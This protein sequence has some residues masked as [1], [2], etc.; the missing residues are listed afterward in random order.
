MPIQKVALIFDDQVR[1]D[2]TGIYCRRALTGLVNVQHFLPS[3]LPQ[4]PRRGF[5][6]YLNIDDGLEYTLPGDLRPCAWWA[7]DTH[8]NLE[9]CQARARDFDL[10]FAAQRDGT[11]QLQEAG[12]STACWL[13]LACD[14]EMHRKHKARKKYNVGFVGHLFPGPRADL[15]SLIQ[16]HFSDT[17]VG[18]CFFEEMAKTYSVSR[19]VFNRSIRNDINM[20]VFEAVACGSLLVTNDLSDNG[21]DDLLRDGVHLATYGNADELLDKIKYYLAHEKIRERIAAAG[22]AEVLGR[23]T[24]RHRMQWLLGEAERVL[25]RLA[26]AVGV[27]PDKDRGQAVRTTNVPAKSS[28]GALV[29]APAATGNRRQGGGIETALGETRAGLLALTPESARKILDMG[30]GDG[31]FGAAVKARQPAEVTGVDSD[32]RMAASA[33]GRIDRVLVGDPGPRSWAFRPTHS[34][35]LSAQECS[36]I[37]TIRCASCAGYATGFVQAVACWQ[38]SVTFAITRLSGPC[39]VGTGPMN[40]RDSA[41][42]TTSDLSRA[43]TSRSCFTAPAS[44]SNNGK[45]SAARGMRNGR[46]KGAAGRFVPAACTWVGCLRRTPRSFTSGEYLLSATPSKLLAFGTTSIVV[47][48]HNQLAYTRMCLES[49]RRRTDEP[50]ELIVVDNGSTDGT[51][52]YLR[53]LDGV[54]VVA[55]AANRGFA[56]GVNQGIQAATGKQIL[57]L[58][59]DCVVTTGWL[60]RLLRA[61][62][63]DRRVGLVGPCSNCVS[64]EQQ[65]QVTYEG[66]LLGLDGFAWDWG[67]A[68]NRRMADTDRLVGFCLLMRRELLDAVGLLDERFGIGCFEDDDY[69]RRALRAG[70]RAVIAQDAF[71]HHFGGRTF[72]GSGVDFAALMWKNQQLFQAKWSQPDKEEEAPRKQHQDPGPSLGGSFTVRATPVRGLALVRQDIELS[73]CMIVRDNARTIEAALQSIKPWVDEMVVVDTGSQDDTPQIARRLGARLFRFPWCDDF[74]A[75]RNESVRHARGRWI[76]WMDSDDTID[77]DNGRKLRELARQ[78]AG[79]SLLGYVVQVHCPGSGEQGDENVTVVDHLKLFRN[80]PQLR[81]NGRIHEQILPA[82]RQAGGE[83]AFTDLFVR[84][85]GYDHSPEGQERKKERDFRL[86]HLELAERP[87]HPFTLFNLGMTCAD[88][89]QYREAVDYLKLSIEH[90]GAGESHLRKAYALLVHA[91]GQLDEREAAWEVCQRGLGLFPEDVELRFRQGILLQQRGQLAEAVKAYRTV[92]ERNGE[93]H[94]SSIDRG[95]RGFK[96]RQLSTRRW[97]TWP[98][99]RNNGARWWRRCRVIGRGGGVWGNSSFSRRKCRRRLLWPSASYGSPICAA[100]VW[101]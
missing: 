40:R 90:S 32:A 5:D 4:V 21:Q 31:R 93:R 48:T 33:K 26:V 73:L 13:P 79:A 62:H 99:P 94:F 11:E 51:L 75:A 8:L 19:L 58:N 86:L 72:V 3:Q 56:A 41:I 20:R 45:A 91:Y 38:A 82:I 54:K 89:G 55:N 50:Y 92:L 47:L 46:D 35:P 16:R 7:I 88:V 12:I 101:C 76:F 84:H 70:Y 66:D 53:S 98:R 80:L 42:V 34:T 6:L 36:S 15:L 69:C 60:L 74:S 83:V 59:N 67:K 49:I 44:A 87:D 77:A 43:A 17:F 2:T 85:S 81:F 28:Q 9:W 25:A 78:P 95:I 64:G 63:S 23:D 27:G 100:R 96:A 57:L 39:W 37:R 52:E 97:V 14:P 68:H 61:L 10:V 24:Y 22:R 30:C 29:E 65:V 18:Q 1:P 71:V